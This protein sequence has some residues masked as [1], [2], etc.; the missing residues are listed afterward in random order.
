[1]AVPFARQS[2][3]TGPILT[4]L[5]SAACLGGGARRNPR[6]PPVRTKRQSLLAGWQLLTSIDRIAIFTL[7]TA[8]SQNGA[9][10]VLRSPDLADTEGVLFRVAAVFENQVVADCNAFGEENMAIGA[11]GAEDRNIPAGGT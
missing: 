5:T 11:S 7:L 8:V 1:M 4:H 3:T 9:A 6:L 10:A 2:A